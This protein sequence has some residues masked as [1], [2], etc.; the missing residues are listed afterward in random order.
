MRLIFQ[1]DIGQDSWR[2]DPSTLFPIL[3]NIVRNKSKNSTDTSD[4]GIKRLPSI[5]TVDELLESL[6]SPLTTPGK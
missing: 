5:K 4:D 6:K 3:K 2:T 1:L